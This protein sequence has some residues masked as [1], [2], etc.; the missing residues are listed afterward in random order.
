MKE[1]IVGTAGHIDHGKTA[2]VEALTGI[3]T[4]RLKEEKARGI[5]IEL[6]F[7]HFTLPSGLTASIV[8]VPGHERFV[9]TMV[10]GATGIDLVLLVVAADEGIMPQTREH[11]DICRLLRVRKGLVV[12]TKVDLVEEEWLQLV[13]ADV[14]EFVK[15][16][17]LEGSPVVRTSVMRGTGIQ[18]L[19]EQLDTLCLNVDER[20]PARFFRLPIDR[21][22]TMK[23]FGTVV[24]GTLMSGKIAEG[25]G[26][27]VAPGGIRS[28]VRG[29]Q[30]H[31]RS[32]KASFSG[33]RTAVN[34]QGVEKEEVARGD[35]LIPP[36]S[37]PP[38]HMV[39]VHLEFLA[40]APRRLKNRARIR[41]HTGTS[42][43]LARLVLLEREELEPGETC[44]AQIRLEVPTVVVYGDPFVIRSYSPILTIGGG[45]ILDGHP[46]KHRR[47][48]PATIDHL[49]ALHHGDLTEVVI[50]IVEDS[51]HKG[52]TRFDLDRRLNLTEDRWEDIAQD[53]RF[54]NG[55]QA[56][57]GALLSSA[58]GTETLLVSQRVY[59]GL[60]QQM[61]DHLERFHVAN[62][63]EPGIPKEDLRGRF[64][65]P[66]HA[67][68]FNH[69]L[70][71]LLRRGEVL[72]AGDRWRSKTHQ[73]QIGKEQEKTLAKMTQV[74]QEAGL[75][76]PSL[77]VVAGELG[78]TEKETRDLAELMV[79]QDIL[80]RIKE[81][82]Y[83][84]SKD[85]QRLQSRLVDFLK[86]RKEISPTEFK[87]MTQLSRK[88][89]I[90]LLEYFDRI[91]LTMRVGDNR[92]LRG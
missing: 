25:E 66:L 24:T 44:Y 82:L 16:A 12:I 81:G 2:L 91:K 68:L 30:A 51:G 71:D 31:N 18:G 58:P 86:E 88:Y 1:V 76:P 37:F 48:N 79:R 43:I 38:T 52:I 3:N 56:A 46:R 29:L 90:P 32:V 41:F 64:R 40:S 89:M 35:V 73:V 65:I 74:F 47:Q 80:V 5:T 45:T 78:Q 72:V 10:A 62:P 63:L 39:D 69:C 6:G 36:D 92:V 57:D 84:P 87:E 70:Q 27:E 8:D 60:A 26:V 77:N 17:F 4:D 23:G 33:M 54:Q 14:R 42:E 59:E 9:K 15:G 19:T 34:L 75:Q 13:E 11:L 61:L 85:I 28:K 55:I 49:E 53:S 50:R 7:A 83:F 67:R 21:V 20:L 22:F